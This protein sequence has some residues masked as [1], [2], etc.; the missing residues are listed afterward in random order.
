MSNYFDNLNQLLNS[1]VVKEM[2]KNA[3]QNKI[4]VLNEQ[5]LALMLQMVDIMKPKRF[6]EIGTAIGFTSISVALFNKDIIVDTIEKNADMYQQA[7]KY[8]ESAKLT[9]RVNVFLGDALEFDLSLINNLYDIIFIDAAKAQ[10]IHFFEKY[11]PLL[12]DGGIIISDNLLFHGLVT[13][14]TPIEN[15]NLKNL[16]EKIRNY[17]T[18]LAKNK[19]FQTLFLEIGDGMAISSRLK[20]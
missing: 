5:G 13:Q 12:N 8:V 3:V 15:K 11:A 18:W 14:D 10:Y 17:N 9:E 19:N 6:L 2:S 16:V 1:K 7:L 4:P 20:K